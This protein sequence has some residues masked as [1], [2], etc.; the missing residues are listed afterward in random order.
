MILLLMGLNG[1]SEKCPKVKY[2]TLDAIDKIPQIKVTVNDG[3]LDRNSTLKTF[4][5]IKALRVSEH[6]YWTLIGD[7]KKEFNK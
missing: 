7:Y 1:C 6:Y 5:T 3:M 2:P 4:K